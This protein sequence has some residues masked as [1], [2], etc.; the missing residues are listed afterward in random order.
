MAAMVEEIEYEGLDNDS[1]A[2]NMIAGACAG[3]AEHAVM[4]PVDSIKVSSWFAGGADEGAG[5][6]WKLTRRRIA[7]TRMQVLSTSPA[8]MYTGMSDA[9]SRITTAEG[10]KRLWRGVGS[11]ILGA[12]PAH[13]IYFGSYEFVKD[14]A[15]GNDKGYSFVATGELSAC[16][17]AMGLGADASS[18][19][20]LA[21]EQRRLS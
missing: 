3:I 18:V 5:S 10:G 14:L 15:G 4:Y 19:L 8:A 7:Q 16:G 20:Q 13:A 21:R 11:V 6:A 9:F 2:I 17:G 12:G 1:L